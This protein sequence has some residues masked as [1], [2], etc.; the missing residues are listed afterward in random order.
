MSKHKTA[1]CVKAN[2]TS[3]RENITAGNVDSNYNF[4]LT[5]HLG[6]YADHAAVKLGMYQ[7][8]PT[9]KLECVM[10]VIKNGW[11]TKLALTI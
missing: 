1:L 11:P 7:G 9:R 4:L 2:S 6:L 10:H 8:M 5:I 3:L